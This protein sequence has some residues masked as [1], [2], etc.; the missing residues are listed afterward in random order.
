MVSPI[1]KPASRCAP[2]RDYG[3]IP[4]SPRGLEAPWNP[5]RAGDFLGSKIH[6]VRGWVKLPC[7]PGEH[8]NK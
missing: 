7:T 1:P 3:R 6:L 4:S 8:Q 5:A 2:W